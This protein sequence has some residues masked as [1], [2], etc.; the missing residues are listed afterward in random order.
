MIKKIYTYLSEHG[1][2]IMICGFALAVASLLIYMQTRYRGTVTPQVAFGCTIFG[3]V[4]Y[5]IGR[6]FLA[7]SRKRN[8]QT[9][10]SQALETKDDM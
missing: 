2:V 10:R 4:V 6:I 7:T 3:F 9:L 5:V 8:R 1:F